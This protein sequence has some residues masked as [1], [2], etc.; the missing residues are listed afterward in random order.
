MAQIGM[1]IGPESL[2]ACFLCP[3]LS[4][5]QLVMRLVGKLKVGLLE[6]RDSNIRCK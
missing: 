3:F 1:P 5:F 4:L 6:M 2:D